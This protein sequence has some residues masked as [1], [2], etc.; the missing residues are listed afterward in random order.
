MAL[1]IQTGSPSKKYKNPPKKFFLKLK[2]ATTVFLPKN[3]KITA[4]KPKFVYFLGGKMLE[5]FFLYSL[6]AFL[7]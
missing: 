7:I 4:P 6:G 3:Y 2:N 5:H 1:K